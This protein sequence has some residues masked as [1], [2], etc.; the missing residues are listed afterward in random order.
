M[1]LACEVKKFDSSWLLSTCTYNGK[2]K[3]PHPAIY[4]KTVD[5]VLQTA[6]GI[7]TGFFGAEWCFFEGKWNPPA[8]LLLRTVR[9]LGR[10]YF[11]WQCDWRRAETSTNAAVAL[12][13]RY[14]RFMCVPSLWCLSNL[15]KD[16][17]GA[18]SWPADSHFATIYSSRDNI[19][20]SKLAVPVISFLCRWWE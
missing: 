15:V 12:W 13:P 20:K 14:I 7:G 16:D 2:D 18:P 10:V 3:K 1:C 17:T 6:A 9:L 11:H 19:G 4:S 8:P 5:L